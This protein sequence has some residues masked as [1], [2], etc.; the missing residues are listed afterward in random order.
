MGRRVAIGAVTATT[1]TTR[2]SIVGVGEP[3]P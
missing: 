1:P 2:L 3:P